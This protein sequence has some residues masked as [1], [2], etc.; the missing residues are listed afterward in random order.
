MTGGVLAGLLVAVSGK[1]GDNRIKAG[2]NMGLLV[3][4]GI[5]LSVITIYGRGGFTHREVELLPFEDILN[6]KANEA[7]HIA[8]NIIL[9]VPFGILMRWMGW[10][11]NMVYLSGLGTSILIEFMQYILSCGTS[12]TDDVICNLA[13]VILGDLIYNIM[14]GTANILRSGRRK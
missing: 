14:K 12:E 7:Y 4:Y 10:K 13:G 2:M 9:F 6:G 5:L 3:C 1:N 8:G 11:R